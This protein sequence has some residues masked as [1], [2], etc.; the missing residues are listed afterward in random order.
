MV[1][2]TDS[3]SVASNRVRVQVS[4]PVSSK[5]FLVL[6]R[7]LFFVQN[8]GSSPQLTNFYNSGI[9]LVHSFLRLMASDMCFG[10]ISGLPSMSA[11]VLETLRQLA[12]ARGEKP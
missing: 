6:L 10:V 3:K 8:P 4:S 5:G 2:T 11:I 7:N 1:D 9:I 12:I